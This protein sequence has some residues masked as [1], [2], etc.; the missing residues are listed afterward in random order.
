MPKVC[1]IKLDASKYHDELSKVEASARD[2]A[3]KVQKI[4]D[5]A[6][7]TAKEGAAAMAPLTSA[8][9][10]VG[11]AAGVSIPPVNALSA[12]LKALKAGA[13]L[14]GLA[15]GVFAA[16]AVKVW[17][18]LTVSTEEF[19][20]K[21]RGSSA[22]AQRHAERIGSLDSAA[23]GYLDRLRELSSTEGAANAARSETLSLLGALERQYG[24]LGAEIDATTGRV[25]NLLEVE[26]RLREARGRRAAEGYEK[27]RAA[28]MGE[29]KAEYIKSQGWEFDWRSASDFDKLAGL[30]PAERLAA[31][32]RRQRDQS[33]DGTEIEHL[34]AAIAKLEEAAEAERKRSASFIK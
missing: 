27:Q 21:M 12:A 13:G 6:G 15:L 28:A 24:D 32:F 29:A 25:S 34:N 9:S 7:A 8:I 30:M 2:A 3:E 10:A 16:V 4:G 18:R 20:A 22:E 5:G 31:E 26:Q 1:R 19:A 11:A 33:K 17:D 23:Q 14:I